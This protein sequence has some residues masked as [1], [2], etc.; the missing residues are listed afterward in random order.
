MPKKPWDKGKVLCLG[1][2]GTAHTFGV[3]LVN[4]SGNIL[5]EVNDSY[6]PQP[7][8]GIIP[9]EAAQHH[10]NVA[11]KVLSKA[12]MQS[13]IKANEI[14]LIA[15]SQGPG[16]GPCLR[17]AATAARALSVFI[18]VPLVGVNHIVAHIEIGK[19]VNRAK[20]PLI[21]VLSGGTTQILSLEE[22]RYRIFGETLD[23]TAANCLDVFAREVGLYDPNAPWPA[24][25]FDEMAEK[26]HSYISLPYTVKGM[27]LQFSGLLTAALKKY[28]EKKFRLEDLCF[29]L[30][31]TVLAM[32]T[33]VAERALAHTEKKE[34]LLIGG[35]AQK[36]RLR[37]MLSIMAKE[38]ETKFFTV[39]RQY[40][41]DNGAMIAWTGILA[42]QSGVT[43]EV[44]KSFVK[45][46][47]R[48]EDVEIPW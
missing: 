15:F 29:S 8:K 39:P 10:S 17:T 44:E 12:L 26:G 23:I 5:A 34:V 7:G 41:T 2:E 35:M 4:S 30:R 1:I 36:A 21:L 24:Y 43:I 32:I 31:E 16:M 9:R 6:I 18:K 19:L 22:G 14:G 11:G 28:R 45:P 48:I 47:W 25:V 3:G 13:G 40:A 27:D 46:K 33:E 37:E 42:Y 38:H 20:D